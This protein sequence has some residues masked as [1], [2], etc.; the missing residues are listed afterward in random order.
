MVP[1][2]PHSPRHGRQVGKLGEGG[3]IVEADEAF[4]GRSPTARKSRYPGKRK[5]NTIFALVE[6]DCAFR[7]RWTVDPGMTDS[8]G[9]KRRKLC[10]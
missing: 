1:L 5:Q 3:G 8:L 9:A 2:A 7:P 10:G 4:I 6:R